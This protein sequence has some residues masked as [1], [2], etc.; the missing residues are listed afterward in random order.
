MLGESFEGKADTTVVFV[1]EVEDVL[2]LFLGML[3]NHLV[4]KLRCN[5]SDTAVKA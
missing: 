5:F 2:L 4:E 1:H 3:N